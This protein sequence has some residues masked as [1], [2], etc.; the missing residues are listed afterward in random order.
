MSQENE[1]RLLFRD[2]MASLSAAVNIVTTD[3]PAGRC[4]ITATAVCSVTDTPP[5]LLVCINRNSAMNPVFQANQRLCVNVLNHEQ[6]LMA[7]HFAGMTELSMEE[8]FR[9]E[10]W[11]NGALD[12]PVLRNT[13]AS[14][15]GEIEQIQSIGTHQVYLVQIRQIRVSAGGNGLIYFKRNF[16]P[17]MHK[18]AALV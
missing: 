10:E 4:G 7:R 18:M 6:E 13:L 3:G 2:A 15:E 14:L 17:V 12:Q 11:Q 8:R 5:T 9:L 16:H 1:H